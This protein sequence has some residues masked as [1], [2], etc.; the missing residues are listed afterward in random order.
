MLIAD[1]LGQLQHS[2]THDV[3]HHY[4]LLALPYIDRKTKSDVKMKK[5]K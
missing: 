3:L 2:L 4:K 5:Q 1:D